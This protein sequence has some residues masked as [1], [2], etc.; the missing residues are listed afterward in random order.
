[1]SE[2]YA[3]IAMLVG[4]PQDSVFTYAVPE[5]MVVRR[6]MAVVAPWRTQWA[7][8]IVI[9]VTAETDLPKT[10][11]IERILDPEPLLTA[12]QLELAAWIA[13]RYL[14]SL[15]SASNS[16]CPRERLPARAA[17]QTRSPCWCPAS[18]RFRSVSYLP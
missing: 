7:L 15:A 12:Q 4:S 8:G 16:S 10:R 17:R 5:E 6:G 9:A 2:R 18:P 14:A 13:E 3:D 1:M 11:E